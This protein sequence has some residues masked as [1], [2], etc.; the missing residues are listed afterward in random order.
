[1][2]HDPSEI[3]IICRFDAQGISLNIIINVEKSFLFCFVFYGNCNTF[4][5]GFY[6]ES[7]YLKY[8]SF[9][10]IINVLTVTFNQFNASVQTKSVNSFQNKCMTVLYKSP[11]RRDYKID[12][13]HGKCQHVSLQMTA[14]SASW[15]KR[16]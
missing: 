6:D 12:H 2:S 1:V 3:I 8:K 4:F 16:L 10:N 14:L 7:K 15:G 5:P 11:F 13:F 9:C